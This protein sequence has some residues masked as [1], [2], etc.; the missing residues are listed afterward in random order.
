VAV[1]ALAVCLVLGVMPARAEAEVVGALEAVSVG[2]PH[3]YPAGS[4]ADAWQHSFSYPGATYVRVH[5]SAFDLVEGDAVTITNPTTGEFYSYDGRGPHGNGAFW[6]F[7][8]AGDTA[9]VTLEASAGG[10]YG[11]EIDS[12]GVGNVDLSSAASPAPEGICGNSNDAR[13]VK[14]YETSRPTEYARARGAV[15]LLIGGIWLCSGFKV[16]D[17]G[18]FMTNN[19][20]IAELGYRAADVEVFLEYQRSACGGGTIGFTSKIMGSQD[21]RADWN[22]DFELFSTT[23]DASSIPCLQMDPRLPAGYPP[24]GEQIY[25]TGH[26]LGQPKQLT[27][28]SDMNASGLCAADFSPYDPAPAPSGLTDVAYY[29]DTLGG[30]SG[31]PVLSG[32]THTVV[33]LHHL[34]CTI[35]CD[36]SCLNSGVRADLICSKISGVLGTCGGGCGPS[37]DGDL[38]GDCCDNCP[39]A[40]NPGQEDADA[41]GLGDACDTC[42]LDP[43][44]DGDRDGVC[45]NVDNC[46]LGYNPAQTDTDADGLG[47]ACDLCPTGPCPTSEP[48]GPEPNPT[49]VKD[50]GPKKR[51]IQGGD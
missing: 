10:G 2:T 11:L 12:V 4:G 22:L 50:P 35:A 47:D 41:D 49:P 16:S 45:G 37:A 15:R 46:P 28:A 39:R 17:S 36:P 33:A 30:S 21:L 38:K 32:V 40:A 31:S 8:I 48:G 1:A 24:A 9:V 51:M 26:P 18:Q 44:N 34:G 25:I 19:H 6:A 7:S 27:I 5:F 3:P 20:C 42:P 23:G 43:Q 14:C 13:D 29:C